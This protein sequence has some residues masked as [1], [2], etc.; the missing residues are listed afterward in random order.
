MWNWQ[1]IEDGLDPLADVGKDR[2]EADKE[3]RDSQAIYHRYKDAERAAERGSSSTRGKRATFCPSISQPDD[4]DDDCRIIEVFD[5][6]PFSYAFPHTV[7]DTTAG[8]G[9]SAAADRGK[10]RATEE[11]AAEPKKK[12]SKKTTSRKVYV[13][14]PPKSKVIGT[15]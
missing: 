5:V 9:D 6:M 13:P 15:G 11:P 12:K 10:K 8:A 1:L 3:D 14:P 4:D 2:A 7:S